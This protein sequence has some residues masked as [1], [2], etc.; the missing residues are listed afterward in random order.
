MFHDRIG[1]KK[2]ES[3]GLRTACGRR[4]RFSCCNSWLNCSD[5]RTKATDSVLAG[6]SVPEVGR[7][8]RSGT[9]PSEASLFC[10]GRSAISVRG[11]GVLDDGMASTISW[12][13]VGG[14]ASFTGVGGVGAGARVLR[15]QRGDG[16]RQRGAGAGWITNTTRGS[17]SAGRA[18]VGRM[19]D[20]SSGT[21]RSEGVAGAGSLESAGWFA[22]GA[23]PN[24]ERGS[25]HHASS[26]PIPSA[27]ANC[28]QP[29]RRRCNRF[30]LR[31]VR[32]K[33]RVRKSA[34]GSSRGNRRML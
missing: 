19:P 6:A 4:G 28:H 1:T 31:V 29:R 17:E 13:E 18:S 26:S 22:I 5:Q 14:A 2:R 11:G 32:A 23:D 27:G 25:V 24:G 8:V 34:G 12:V 15:I 33:I 30:G 3:R 7:S 10:T 21:T 20:D 16:S 9:I